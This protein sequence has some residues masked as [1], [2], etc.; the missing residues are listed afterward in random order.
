MEKVLFVECCKPYRC[1]FGPVFYMKFLEDFSN[2]TLMI[3]ES[4]LK[5]LC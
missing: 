1:G 2:I 3:K 4:T 5:V